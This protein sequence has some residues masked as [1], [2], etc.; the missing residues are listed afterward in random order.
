MLISKPLSDSAVSSNIDEFND[1]HGACV[2]YKLVIIDWFEIFSDETD[3]VCYIKY[4]NFLND[5][6]PKI[7]KILAFIGVDWADEVSNFAENAAKLAVRT[8]SY[9]NVRKAVTIVVQIFWQNFDFLFGDRFRQLLDPW[10]K[11]FGYA[12]LALMVTFDADDDVIRFN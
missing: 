8:P 1:I 6:E 7:S 5:F 4:D 12:Q 2:R 9:I 11:R 10:M 3:R